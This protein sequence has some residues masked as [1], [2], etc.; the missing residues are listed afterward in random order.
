MR[1]LIARLEKATLGDLDDLS[2][3]IAKHVGTWELI[4]D[5]FHSYPLYCSGIDAALTLVPEGWGYS[6]DCLPPQVPWA[7]VTTCPGQARFIQAGGSTPALALCIAA[8][9]ARTED[10]APRASA[11]P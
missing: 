2:A 10:R 8:L 11:T 1:E 5:R 4:E 3:Q 9:K 6:I 7:T